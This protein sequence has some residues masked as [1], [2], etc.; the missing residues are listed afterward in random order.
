MRLSRKFVLYGAVSVEMVSGHGRR[1]GWERVADNAERYT[2]RTCVHS[3]SFCNGKLI[4]RGSIANT[5]M[6]RIWCRFFFFKEDIC[7]VIVNVTITKM[8]RMAPIDQVFVA[9][10]MTEFKMN[11]CIIRFCR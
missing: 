5:I 8:S 10:K 2:R 9:E 6:R 4:Y 11:Y 1:R 7:I 3:R